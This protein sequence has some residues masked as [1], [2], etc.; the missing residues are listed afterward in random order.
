MA[1]MAIDTFPS[2]P[3]L[4]PTGT[5]RPEASSRWIW[6]SVVRA[7]I[8][9][10]ETRS[11]KNWGVKVSRNSQPQGIPVS[12]MVRRRERAIRRPL[13]IWKELSGFIRNWIL[14]NCLLDC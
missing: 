14:V 6:D 9:P 5:E 10:Q 7:P 8:A 1:S 11:P 13:L 2:V 4:N 12:L 3:F